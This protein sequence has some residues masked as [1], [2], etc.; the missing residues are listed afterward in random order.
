[1]ANSDPFTGYNFCRQYDFFGFYHGERLRIFFENFLQV[2][3]FDFVVDNLLKAVDRG[4]RAVS[5]VL[6]ASCIVFM[7]AI[8]QGNFDNF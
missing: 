5:T 1:M 6:H 7:P 8:F 2:F 3:F 4:N